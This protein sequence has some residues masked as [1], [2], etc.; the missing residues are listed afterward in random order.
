MQNTTKNLHKQ[1]GTSS[2]LLILAS[3]ID[4]KVPKTPIVLKAGLIYSKTDSR[5]HCIRLHRFY[6]VDKEKQLYA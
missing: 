6:V 3:Y 5:P 2:K 1:E 4:K